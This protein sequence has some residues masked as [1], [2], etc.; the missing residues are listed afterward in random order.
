MNKHNDTSLIADRYG[1]TESSKK[2]I[3]LAAWIFGALF[4]VGFGLFVIFQ[5]WNAASSINVQVINMRVD[6]QTQFTVDLLADAPPG[7][8]YQCAIEVQSAGKGVVGWKIVDFNAVNAWSQSVT[9]PINTTESG[10]SGLI[11]GCWLP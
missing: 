7:T 9:V 6:S 5:N 1:S 11:S 2:N 8:K 10:A 3:K 4:A